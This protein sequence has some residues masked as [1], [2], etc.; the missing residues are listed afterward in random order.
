MK[1]KCTLPSKVST[2][3]LKEMLGCI[4]PISCN[5]FGN[6]VVKAVLE[7]GPKEFQLQCARRLTLSFQTPSSASL[8]AG[9]LYSSL[10]PAIKDDLESFNYQKVAF[11]TLPVLDATTNESMPDEFL[12]QNL[13]SKENKGRG[14]SIWNKKYGAR[15]ITQ[16]K[17]KLAES[18][19]KL[20]DRPP[21]WQ[22]I[23]FTD[24]IVGGPFGSSVAS[25]AQAA[26]SLVAGRPSSSFIF[27]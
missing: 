1:R 16:M 10:S 26:H 27:I 24:T 11:Q 6:W 19:K 9:L 20:K 25:P 8:I 5:E 21:V 15:N 4:V 22:H 12:V 13:H 17:E 23:F 2:R 7:S 18:S 3:I 14:R